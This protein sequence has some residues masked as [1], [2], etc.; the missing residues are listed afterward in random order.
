MKASKLTHTSL[1]KLV[2][3][4]AS[5]ALAQD[6]AEIIGDI[7]KVNRLF[8]KLEE[9]E[10]ELKSR[11]GDQRRQLMSL[12]EHPNAQVR[13][14]AASATLAIAPQAAR[15]VLERIQRLKEFPQA[16]EAGMRLRHI[17]QGFYKPT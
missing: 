4:F 17:D 11:S 15:A 16:G 1:E 9:I 13:L 6:R 12:Y 5:L 7:A 8:D 14:K 2:Q 10:S 3:E